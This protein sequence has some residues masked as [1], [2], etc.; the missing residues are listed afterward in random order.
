MTI[1]WQQLMDFAKNQLK[2]RPLLKLV[3][4]SKSDRDQRAIAAARESIQTLQGMVG[5][6]DVQ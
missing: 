1:D 5:V 6:I 2:K 3:A 4:L